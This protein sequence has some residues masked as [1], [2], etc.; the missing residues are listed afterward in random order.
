LSIC[1]SAS[2]SGENS[3]GFLAGFGA[4]VPKVGTPEAPKGV[5]IRPFE[6]LA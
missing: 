5:S 6:V 2:S 1:R 4:S 3:P